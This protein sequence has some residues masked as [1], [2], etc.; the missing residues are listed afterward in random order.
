MNLEH[1]NNTPKVMPY[2]AKYGNVDASLLSE[3]QAK[4][5]LDEQDSV[6]E[7]LVGGTSIWWQKVINSGLKDNY[8][9]S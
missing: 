3:F 9:G 4:D 6:E 2:I 7:I 8:R 5:I 1:G